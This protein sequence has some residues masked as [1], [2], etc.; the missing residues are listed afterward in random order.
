MR[1]MLWVLISIIGAYINLYSDNVEE[2]FELLGN[3]IDT[4]N[5]T[6]NISGT[7]CYCKPCVEDEL[8]SNCDQGIVQ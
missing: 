4:D 8:F 6:A 1:P 5:I 3:F 2:A 7:Y